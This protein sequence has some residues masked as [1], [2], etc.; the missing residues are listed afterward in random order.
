[1]EIIHKS[2]EAFKA[3][4]LAYKSAKTAKTAFVTSSRLS[5]DLSE[6]KPHQEESHS[7]GSKILHVVFSKT[8]S[9]M[10][11]VASGAILFGIISNPITAGVVLGA[12]L[13]S[14]GIGV[15]WEV[16]KKRN[17]RGLE[18]DRALLAKGLDA[19][20]AKKELYKLNPGLNTLLPPKNQSAVTHSSDKNHPPAHPSASQS[21]PSLTKPSIFRSVL[22]AI[23]DGGAE[24]YIPLA[25]SAVTTAI[26]PMALASFII[27]GVGIV[28]GTAASSYER[29]KDDEYKSVVKNDRIK[30]LH[31]FRKEANAEIQSKAQLK[32]A[33]WEEEIEQRALKKLTESKDPKIISILKGD[34]KAGDADEKTF[35][36]AF[37]QAKNQAVSEYPFEKPKTLLQKTAQLGKDYVTV[38]KDGFGLHHK[39]KAH[40]VPAANAGDPDKGHSHTHAQT[41]NPVTKQEKIKDPLIDVSHIEFT[42][43]HELT[44]STHKTT[45]PVAQ[46]KFAEKVNRRSEKIAKAGKAMMQAGGAGM[47][48]AFFG[49][50]AA[51]LD[52]ATALSTIAP[53]VGVGAAAVIIGAQLTKLGVRRFGKKS[54][55]AQK[56]ESM[57]AKP[58]ETPHVTAVE[59]SKRSGTISH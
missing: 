44:S 31:N 59:T 48:G 11:A 50:G 57:P 49:A 37:E 51:G 5:E 42:H 17:L 45:S 55:E 14:I 24:N 46:T 38:I 9:R 6:K 10:V 25:V 12:T 15:S 27:S 40:E 53:V 52:V 39:S 32:K 19:T 33:V 20:Q 2:L 58:I 30:F 18:E 7:V 22:K 28:M 34:F 47:T 41:E 1:M 35:K 26:N 4:T 13:L 23:R 3:A 21:S 43:E 29:Y 56:S 8:A 54:V 36:A 16:H